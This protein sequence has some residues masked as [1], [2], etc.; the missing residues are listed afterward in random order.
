[1]KVGIVG[2]GV[3]G[4]AAARALQSAGHQAVVFEKSPRVGGRVATRPVGEYLFDSGCSD[5]VPRGRAIEKVMLH[6]LDTSD[7]VE[8]E[9]PLY[10]H[11]SL[12]P[13]AAEP[14]NGIAR[15]TYKS[16]NNRFAQ[17]LAQGLDVRLSTQ[18]D[19]LDRTTAG[20]RVLGE[21]F[22]GLILTPPVP[23]TAALLWTLGESRAFANV[24]YRPCL[25]VMLGFAREL[26]EMHYHALLD[27][28]QRH[29]LMW[30]S[31]ESVKWAGRAPAGHTAMVAQLSP[32][33]SLSSF[34]AED[35]RIVE[36]TLDYIVWLYG[37]DWRQPE[38]AEVKR[39]K[40]SQP[41]S[42]ALFDTVNDSGSKLVIAGDGVLAG[43]VENAFDTGL[44]AARLVS[45]DP[46]LQATG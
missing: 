32:S 44:M 11:H 42:V 16:G 17:L 39:W 33:Y 41:D 38:V 24:R 43:R 35:R 23:Q 15:Y 31:L 45:G 2:A 7:L 30:L 19:T 13:A 22:D 1:M 40:Y 26:P 9:K 3:A 20:F 29:P 18:V 36:D 27:P 28:E 37:Q 12:R 10:F 4:L 6:E 5:L 25:S 14:R 21:E 8:I 34:A 46:I